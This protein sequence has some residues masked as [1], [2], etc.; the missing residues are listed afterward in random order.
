MEQEN[1]KVRDVPNMHKAFELLQKSI[2]KQYRIDMK[3]L[4]PFENYEFT[5][6][7]GKIVDVGL[8]PNAI[9]VSLSS[10]GSPEKFESIRMKEVTINDD[11]SMILFTY[12]DNS[13]FKVYISEG[14]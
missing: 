3:T 2:G 4:S 10:G 9:F 8:Y 12:L 11:E 14:K 7:S 6:A 13:Y 1:R 5:L